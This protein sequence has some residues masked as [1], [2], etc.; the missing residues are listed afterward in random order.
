LDTSREFEAVAAALSLLGAHLH[1]IPGMEGVG[2][3]INV[4]VYKSDDQSADLKETL[5]T[6]FS[7]TTSVPR[8]KF[9]RAKKALRLSDIQ[10]QRLD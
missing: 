10:R 8:F 1:F 6:T 5:N 3:W 7:A 4:N 9:F 2:I